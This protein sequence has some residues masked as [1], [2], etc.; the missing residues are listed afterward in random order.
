MTSRCRTTRYDSECNTNSKCPTN[1]KQRSKSGYAQRV[2][3]V[4]SEAC[5]GSNTREAEVINLS[6]YVLHLG[7][8]GALVKLTRR[9]IRP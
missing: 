3:S 8:W 9:R 2:G 5:S 1:L 4:E 6:D 7:E